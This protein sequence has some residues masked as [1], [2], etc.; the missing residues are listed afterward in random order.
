MS[1]EM[2]LIHHGIK[3][4]KW[5]VRRFQNEDGTRTAAGKKHEKTLD[6]YD[7]KSSEKSNAR[8]EYRQAKKEYNKATNAYIRRTGPGTGI[9][10]GQRAKRYAAF[11]K[12]SESGKKYDAAKERYKTERKEARAEAKKR[13]DSIRKS[14][15]VGERAAAFMVGGVTGSRSV[16]NFMAVGNSKGAAYAKTFLAGQGNLLSSTIHRNIN[17]ERQKFN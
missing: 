5:G 7:S 13:A 15:T 6:S 1:E 2:I 8:Q 12:M 11:E 9:T 4:Q 17:A 3:G 10:A 16:A 14:M